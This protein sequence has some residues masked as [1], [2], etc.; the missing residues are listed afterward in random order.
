MR[1][2][3]TG[4][5]F[6]MLVLGVL[7]EPV[8]HAAAYVLRYGPSQA[9]Q[10]QSQGSHASFAR[11]FSVSSVSLALL[12]GLGLLAVVSVRLILG[13]RPTYRAGLPSSFAILAGTQCAF[14]VVK[15]TLEAIAFHTHPD[16]LAIAVLAVVAQLPLAALVAWLI[17]WMRG[18]M[19]LAPEA[20]RALLIVRAGHGRPPQLVRAATS[21]SFASDL[22][23]HR[24][25][26]RRGPPLSN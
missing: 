5:L 3:T 1:G 11:V 14:F 4:R 17:S 24:W 8:G 23:D 6:A 12:L 15:E 20:I 16:F 13:S 25:Y 2:L 9:W 18:Y 21:P 10:L 22:R 7:L 19:Q 26:R